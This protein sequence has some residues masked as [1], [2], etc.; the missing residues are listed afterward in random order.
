MKSEKVLFKMSVTETLLLLVFFLTIFNGFVFVLS[1]LI[2]RPGFLLYDSAWI[3]QIFFPVLYSII[4]TSINRNGVLKISDYNDL[5]SLLQKIES[6]VLKKGYISADPPVI[7]LTSID[8]NSLGLAYI[9]KTKWGRFFNY[10]FREDINLQIK[11]DEVL[12]FTKRNLI[13]SFLM[14]LKYS[15]ANHKTRQEVL[16]QTLKEV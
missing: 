11:K 9:R 14:E 1:L 16:D 3:P 7:D 6:L 15:P 8:S 5:P 4:Q 13:L 10:F 2:G 12:I